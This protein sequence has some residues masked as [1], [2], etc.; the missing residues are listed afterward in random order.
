MGSKPPR[1]PAASGHRRRFARGKAT[2]SVEALRDKVKALMPRARSD[3]A[4]MMSFKSVHDATQF[5]PEECAGMVDW[6][7]GAFTEV[8]LQDGRA[9]DPRDGSVAVCGHADGPPGAPTVLLYFHH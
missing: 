6:L 1:W 5:P 4:Q 7:L 9:Y 3:L 8:G 2:V